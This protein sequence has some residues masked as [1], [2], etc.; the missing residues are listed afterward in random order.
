MGCDRSVTMTSRKN[1][2][3][4]MKLIDVLR[5]ECIVVGAVFHDE[6]EV[7]RQ[8]MQVATMPTVRRLSSRWEFG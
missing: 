1:E 7:L 6:A 4:K 3:H 2:K 8:V 5:E